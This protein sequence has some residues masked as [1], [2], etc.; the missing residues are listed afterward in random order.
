MAGMV[1]IAARVEQ[2]IS[3]LT[4]DELVGIVEGP[5]DD[6]EQWALEIARSELSRRGLSSW[7]VARIHSE[8]AK[9]VAEAPASFTPQG[10]FVQKTALQLFIVISVV[11]FP[12]AFVLASKAAQQGNVRMAKLLRFLGWSGMFLYACFAVFFIVASLDRR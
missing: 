3:Q 8:N 4:D 11:A 9:P 10:V 2:R 12:V 6:Y 1:D 7:D 5:P